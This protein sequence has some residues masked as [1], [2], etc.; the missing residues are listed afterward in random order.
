MKIG[1]IQPGGQADT[2]ANSQIKVCKKV[3]FSNNII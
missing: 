3:Q 1:Q 2:Q